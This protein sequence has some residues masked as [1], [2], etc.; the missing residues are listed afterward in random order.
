MKGEISEDKEEKRRGET[1]TDDWER[2]KQGTRKRKKEKEKREGEIG[3]WDS[4]S[5]LVHLSALL[6][7]LSLHA[8]SDLVNLV[9]SAP[10]SVLEGR[11]NTAVGL[12]RP[13]GK[14]IRYITS[15]RERDRDREREREKKEETGERG[16][17]G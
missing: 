3:N 7:L 12:L 9:L 8:L 6:S 15:I 14:T 13:K 1:R 17:R 16:R 5:D 2:A 4:V 10:A 11:R